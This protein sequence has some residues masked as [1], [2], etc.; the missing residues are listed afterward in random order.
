MLYSSLELDFYG[1]GEVDALG[2]EAL[3]YEL[4]PKGGALQAKYRLGD[5]HFW[6][7]LGY[8]FVTADVAFDAPAE[9][10]GLPDYRGETDIGGLTP[11]VTFDTRDNIFTPIRGTYVEGSVSLFADE[12]GGDD[13]FERGRLVAMQFIPFGDRFYLGLRGDAAFSSGDVPFYLR[14]FV[15]LRGVPALRYQGDETAQLEVELRW[16]FWK[17]L[18][19]VG[20]GGVGEAWTDAE[21]ADD[22]GAVTTIGT[23]V[24]YEIARRYGIHVGADVAFGPEETAFYV[25]FGSAWARP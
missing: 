18:S 19:A 21:R 6:A 12:L 4:E 10:P 24:R 5:T 3:R 25:Q 7:G 20:F 2:G 9:T 23:G 17:R 16:Q 14:P 22:S 11:S 13:D 15:S 1:I 8:A